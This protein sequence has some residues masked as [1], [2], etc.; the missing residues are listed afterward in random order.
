[1]SVVQGLVACGAVQGAVQGAVPCQQHWYQD[2]SIMGVAS[3]HTSIVSEQMHPAHALTST[4]NP[5]KQTQM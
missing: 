3:V 2:R 5:L 4:I 1:M